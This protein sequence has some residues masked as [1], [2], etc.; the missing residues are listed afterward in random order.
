M[1]IGCTV[2]LR[3]AKMFD[4]LDKLFNVALPRLRD[5]RGLSEKG[6]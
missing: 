2:T 5:F 6:F 4:F 3:R 1:P